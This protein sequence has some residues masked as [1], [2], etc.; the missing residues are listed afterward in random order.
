M[1]RYVQ[2]DTIYLRV[3]KT[4]LYQKEEGE[5]GMEWQK[6]NFIGNVL[7]LKPGGGT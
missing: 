1:K 7:F 4:N 6:N 3:K 2:N 5:K